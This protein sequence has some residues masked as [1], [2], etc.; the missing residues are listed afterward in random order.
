MLIDNWNSFGIK[1]ERAC[2]VAYRFFGTFRRLAQ[3]FQFT[4]ESTVMAA[5]LAS[6]YPDTII[7]N[8]Q[9]A[10]PPYPTTYIEYN[11][12]AWADAFGL[13]NYDCEQT[14]M[15]TKVGHLI[16]DMAV[17][18]AI[19]LGDVLKDLKIKTGVCPWMYTLD[20]NKG[21]LNNMKQ[22][23]W[24]TEGTKKLRDPKLCHAAMLLGTSLNHARAS[25]TDEILEDLNTRVR[26]YVE[27]T[28]K[29][30]DCTDLIKTFIGEMRT[31]WALLLFLNQPSHI[32]FDE[33]PASAR[34]IGHKRIAT[35][36]FRL[37][38]VKPKTTVHHIQKALT[39]RGKPGH[40]QVREFWRN[41]DKNEQCNHSWPL[42]PDDE[43][44]FQCNSCSQWR[45]R[46]TSH[47]RGDEKR[48]VI[49]RGYQV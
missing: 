27:H 37:V 19:D 42:M 5:R 12:R 25:I 41:F 22:V 17:A 11:S 2:P 48:P 40:H 14:D 39:A 15:D 36:R 18:T 44:V 29:S 7:H 46:V 33:I 4:D 1:N 13:N 20:S 26:L 16:H 32:I 24:D 45:V 38:R 8:Y 34:M 43:G 23:C 35:P 9:F 31:L 49:R 3:R 21:Y 30:V 47:W 6:E 10:L 28:V